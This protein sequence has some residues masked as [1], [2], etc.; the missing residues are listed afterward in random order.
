M[1]DGVEM[2]SVKADRGIAGMTAVVTFSSH[3]AAT[4]AKKMLIEGR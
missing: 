1:C 3:S 4:N 2:V